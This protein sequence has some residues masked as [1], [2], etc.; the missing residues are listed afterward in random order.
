MKITIDLTPAEAD[1]L[2]A[3][4]ERLG[5]EVESVLKIAL[6]HQLPPVMSLAEAIEEADIERNL[7]RCQ[8]SLAEALAEDRASRTPALEE[9]LTKNGM[10]LKK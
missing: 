1:Q 9:W 10:R 7:H 3:K 5:L 2:N 4:A 8:T 6:N